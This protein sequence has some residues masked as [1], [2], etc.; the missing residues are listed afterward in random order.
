MQNISEDRCDPTKQ[1][2]QTFTVSGGGGLEL[3]GGGDDWGGSIMFIL[4]TVF[5]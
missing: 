1:L 4:S 5:T 3:A 2:L